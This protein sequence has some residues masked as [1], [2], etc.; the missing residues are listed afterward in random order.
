MRKTVIFISLILFSCK[1][2]KTIEQ[3]Y[4]TQN[5][6]GCSS[7]MGV[8]DYFSF[9]LGTWW[10]YEE[11]TSK[12]RD[13]VFVTESLNNFSN[14]Q[15]ETRIYS[16]F[17]DYFYHFFPFY[18]EGSS[19]CNPSGIINT[20]CIRVKRSK[21]KQGDFV[22]ESTCFMF[23][24]KKGM[25]SFNFASNSSQEGN[26]VIVEEIFPTYNLQGLTFETTVKMHEL[27]NHAENEQATN[28]YFSKG[29]GLV[30]KELLDSNQVWNLV[31]YHIQP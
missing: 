29:V 31:N 30:R 3:P 20:S 12:K 8:K 26:R 11:E 9:K 25:Y 19:A 15:F 7:I 13:S 23:V 27:F 1:E 5:P 16:V 22:S 4:C 28:H 21:Y 24:F 18:S 10:V 14:Y 6:E 2:D 17:E